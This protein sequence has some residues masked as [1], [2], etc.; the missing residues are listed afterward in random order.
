MKKVII[1]CSDSAF[2]NAELIG[3]W[4]RGENGWSEIGYHFVILNGRTDAKF[5]YD[6]LYDGLIETGRHILEDGAHTKGQNTESIGI[7][8]I[9]KSNEFTDVQMNKLE[10]LLII[11][12]AK[13]NELDIFQHSDFDPHN[14]PYCAG[15]TDSIMTDLRHKFGAL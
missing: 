7:C 11:L 6:S 9:G 14:K 15:L 12:M 10:Q 2:G 1:H 3:S 13:F 4:H 8:L 5:K